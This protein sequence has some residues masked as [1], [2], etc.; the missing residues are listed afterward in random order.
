MAGAGGGRGR[1]LRMSIE[2]VAKKLSLWHTA[3]FRPILTHD[4]LEPILAAAG[5]VP[6]PPS[7]HQQQQ[8]CLPAAAGAAVAWREYAFLGCNANARRRPG[9]G[10]RPRLPHPRLDGLHLKTYEAFLG[11]VEAYL[12]ADRVSNLFH[13]RYAPPRLARSSV[14]SRHANAAA[15][16]SLAP[17]PPAPGFGLTRARPA[18]S[19]PFLPM[20]LL[21]SCS[22]R[23]GGSGLSRALGTLAVA[24]ARP[25]S[26]AR[27]HR[28]RR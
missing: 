3:T 16:A 9:P 4:E 7:Q 13:V 27:A 22:D 8:E 6:A 15:C 23:L 11:A 14:A 28:R 24:R 26:V 2:E 19:V 5:F 20:I 10:P 1:E 25:G 12:G 18:A 21:A 17:L